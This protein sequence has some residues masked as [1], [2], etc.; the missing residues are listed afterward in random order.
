MNATPIV[1]LTGADGFIGRALAPHLRGAG[2]DVR[3]IVRKAPVKLAGP[4]LVVGDLAAADDAALRNALAGAS[5]VVHLAGRA[6]RV[7]ETGSDAAAAYRSDNVR[8]TERVAR[9][10]AEA[11]VRHFV[12]ASSVKV[13]GEWT[14]PGR[15]FTPDDPPSPADAY[16]RSKRDAEAELLAVADASRMRAS[17]LRLPLVHGRGARGNFARLVEG[18][19]SGAWLPIG[20]I[21]NR[22]SV[23][24]LPNLCRAVIALL[25]APASES[26]LYFVADRDSVST[27][28]LVRAIAAALGVR[29]RLANV[30]V[31]LL[32]VAALATGRGAMFDRL[33]RSLEVD[34]TSFLARTG[35]S[36]MPFAIDPAIAAP[37]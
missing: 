36:P 20:A 28:E 21:D 26:G 22:R 5:A 4:A 33:A 2:F 11:G 8:A 25:R 23:L 27:P 7:A 31:P 10:A 29:P 17:I 1:A 37:D 18:V 14:A 16:A 9:A 30:P 13:N 32:R 34:T 3:P 15:P 6:H 12:F 19:R 35:F 24:G